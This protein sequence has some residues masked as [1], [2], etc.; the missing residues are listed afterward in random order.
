MIAQR[1]YLRVDIDFGAGNG[2]RY[3]FSPGEGF[4]AAFGR[5]QAELPSLISSPSRMR[6]SLIAF[7]GARRPAPLEQDPLERMLLSLASQP[8]G[9]PQLTSGQ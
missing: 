6:F 5:A 4:A 7:G 3:V 9:A 2:A 8:R 1:L